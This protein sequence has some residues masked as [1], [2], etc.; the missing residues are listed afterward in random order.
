MMSYTRPTANNPECADFLHHFNMLVDVKNHQ[1]LDGLTHLSVQGIVTLD[2]QPS[3]TISLS[4]FSVTSPR[5]HKCIL[6]SV[7][8]S[9]M[10][11]HI[12]TT[13]PPVSAHA[14]RVASTTCCNWALST[15]LRAA[16]HLHYTWCQRRHWVTGCPVVIIVLLITV[17]PLTV[18]PSPVSK[19]L[20]HLYMVL[21]S[22][23]R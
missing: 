7:L 20:R 17:P 5:S 4:P 13:G 12:T 18:T 2:L 10:F 9:T 22:S 6:L 8:Y 23:P 21:Q 19:I 3:P 11:H 14:R 15:H 1:L 16:G